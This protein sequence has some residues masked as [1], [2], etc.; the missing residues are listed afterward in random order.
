MLITIT[1]YYNAMEWSFVS[2]S[3]PAEI[4]FEGHQYTVAHCSTNFGR[5]KVITCS[6]RIDIIRCLF[7]NFPPFP[8]NLP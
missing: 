7:A 6:N 8:S 4:M 2:N 1:K 3:L 5:K